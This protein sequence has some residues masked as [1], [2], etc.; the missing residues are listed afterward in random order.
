[1][2]A[3]LICMALANKE[4]YLSNMMAELGFGKLFHSV[5][6]LLDNTDVLYI[7][8]HSTYRS[9]TRHIALR[10]V[11]LKEVVKEG[12]TTIH[13]VVITRHLADMGTKFLI[14]GTHRHLLE[15]IKGYTGKEKE[16]RNEEIH[17]RST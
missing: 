11:F 3:E 16:Q 1:M 6:L 12:R 5:A 15:L 13:N 2:E 7:A 4:I 10:I 17:T 9:R 14:K 8:G